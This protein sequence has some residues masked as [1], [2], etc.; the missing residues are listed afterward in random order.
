MQFQRVDATNDDEFMAWFDVLNRAELLRDHGR[1][2]GWRPQEWRARA[3]DD[4]SPAYHQ[5]FRFGDDALAPVAVGTLEISR[6]DN[7]HWIR[8]DLFVDPTQRRRGY[9]SELLTHLEAT[10]RDLGRAAIL[11]WV[12]EDATERGAGPNRGFAP[13]HGYDV[14]EENVQRDLDW[15]RPP[16]E[17]DRLER[18][19]REHARGYEILSWRDATPE[20][21]LEGRAHLMAIMPVEVPDAGYGLEEER[22]DAARLRAHE[23]RTHEMGRDLLVA[24]A[25][26]RT[27]AALVGFSELSV[28]RE[29]PGTAYQWDTLV[30]RAH[31]GHRLGG[32]L[33]IA[34]MRL[35]AAGGYETHQIM[36]SNNERNVAMIA[37]NEALGARASGGI[38]TW[39][40]RLT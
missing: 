25:R 6:V 23:Q 13:R 24:V 30:T 8:G 4:Q 16:G 1:H 32:L 5:L 17:L 37:V 40:K 19:W 2:E 15:P 10:A 28:S 11:F 3:L 9:G 20:S 27:S 26:E 35:L 31:R 39:H 12:P 22:W 33:K 36:T 14:V 29:R 21:L 34:T 7:L 38:V 18:S